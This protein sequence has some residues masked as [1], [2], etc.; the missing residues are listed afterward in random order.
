MNWKLGLFVAC[1]VA[2]T[3]VPGTARAQDYTLHYTQAGAL[4]DYSEV[5]LRILYAAVTAREYDPKVTKD[6]LAELKDALGKAKRHAGRAAT[7]L[8]ENLM[9][10]EPAVEKLRAEIGKAEDQLVKLSTDIE[11]QTK[12]LFADEEEVEL[13]ERA[14]D[15]G[16]AAP[17]KTDWDLLKKGAGWLG[18]DLKGCKRMHKSL[19]RKLKVK[20]LKAPPK[21]RGKRPE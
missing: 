8:P 4:L 20:G 3:S 13:G 11:E 16:E 7:L 15:S 1:A 6:T 9:K 12:A 17:A 2:A 10:H 19:A 21:P 18:V 14:E 5:E